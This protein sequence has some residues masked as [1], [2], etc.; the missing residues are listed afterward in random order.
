MCR[1]PSMHAASLQHLHSI[2][3][4]GIPSMLRRFSSLRGHTRWAVHPPRHTYRGQMQSGAGL[5]SCANQ[6]SS[7]SSSAAPDMMDTIGTGTIAQSSTEAQPGGAAQGPEHGQACDKDPYPGP[8][9]GY[10]SPDQIA[11]SMSGG[12]QAP[13]P[14]FQ[15]ARTQAPMY[16]CTHVGNYLM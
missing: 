4:H 6:Q 13:P 1:L 12:V 5:A 11:K 7:S 16:T 8:G 2:H 3:T 15:H 9:Q 10:G 14:P